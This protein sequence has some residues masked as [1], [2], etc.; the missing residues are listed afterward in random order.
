[1]TVAGAA[2]ATEVL[3]VARHWRSNA[4][5]DP[6]ANGG[7]ACLPKARWPMPEPYAVK[8]AC[9]VLRGR[10]WREPPLLPD[11]S[12]PALFAVGVL[13]ALDV[14]AFSRFAAPPLRVKW[15][16]RWGVRRGENRGRSIRSTL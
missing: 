7:T 9:T 2:S 16:L 3:S 12:R 8:V 10:G 6:K 13:A 5:V 11:L 4:Q 14:P 1:M 15:L